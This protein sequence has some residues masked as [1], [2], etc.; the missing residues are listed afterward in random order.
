MNKIPLWLWL[1]IIAAIVG[2]GTA[3]YTG[4]RGLRNNNPG[5]IRHGSQ[6]D[7]MS[8]VQSD[9]EF[10]TFASPVYGIRAM[11]RVLKNYQSLYG[12]DTIEKIITRWA[13]PKENDTASYIAQVVDATGIPARTPVAVSSILPRLIP[14][15]IH[16]ENGSQPY[17][18]DIL[19][20]GIALAA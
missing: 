15:M 9:P 13:P 18:Q 2:G 16:H 10:I 7:G 4:A 5:N 20:R 14:A 19:L 1:V 8:A 3:A 11:A 12:L 6:W 17:S